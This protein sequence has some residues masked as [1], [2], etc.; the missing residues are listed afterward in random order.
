MT[1]K[2]ANR[3]ET[4]LAREE[5]LYRDGGDD[6]NV[7]STENTEPDT[8]TSRIMSMVHDRS[9]Q[10]GLLDI[11]PSSLWHIWMVSAFDALSKYIEPQEYE[12][13][14]KRFSSILEQRVKTGAW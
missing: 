1:T 12:S 13:F 10:V 8:I 11:M 5:L 4:N 7:M 3:L 2:I 14:L 6:V 9:L